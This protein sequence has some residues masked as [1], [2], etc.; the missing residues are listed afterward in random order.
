MSGS[1]VRRRYFS[2]QA[3]ETFEWLAP[4]IGPEAAVWFVVASDDL[5]LSKVGITVV[6]LSMTAAAATH[7]IVLL[8]A[9]SPFLA[10]CAFGL[11]YV[12]LPIRRSRRIGSEAIAHTLKGSPG[13]AE[14]ARSYQQWCINHALP[15][16]PFRSVVA[17]LSLDDAW[18]AAKRAR[19]YRRTIKSRPPTT[20]PAVPGYRYQSAP[21][22]PLPPAGFV[23]P[24][25]WRPDP[26][27]PPAPTSWLFWTVDESW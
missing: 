18:V 15:A 6:G 13:V 24:I 9:L 17:G 12:S 14:S 2:R 1:S 21:G 19:R 16:Y 4:R 3:R 27:W 22:W 23:P 20:A 7:Q 10:A 11:V 25:D 26:S 5:L 8:W